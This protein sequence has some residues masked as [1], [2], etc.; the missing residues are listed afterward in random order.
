M[1][2]QTTNLFSPALLGGSAA[3]FY[4][5]PGTPSTVV[6]YQGRVRLTNTDSVSHA[7]TMY[8]IPFGSSASITTECL[9]AYP[10]AA[11]GYLDLA[12]PMLGASGFYQAFADTG[13]KV[14][15]TPL[16]GVLLS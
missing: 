13:A 5:V 7:V 4:T 15:V 6:L 16:A 9:S 1:A 2:V 11:N 14:S 12:L 3:T 8:A 10:I